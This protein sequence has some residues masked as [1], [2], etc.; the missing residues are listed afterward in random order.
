MEWFKNHMSMIVHKKNDQ[1]VLSGQKLQC[2]EKETTHEIP[3][4]AFDK[5]DSLFLTE[6]TRHT[7]MKCQKKAKQNTEQ[8]NDLRYEKKNTAS[9]PKMKRYQQHCLS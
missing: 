1:N 4:N 6:K 3:K 9:T 8:R 2:I 7:E 5:R